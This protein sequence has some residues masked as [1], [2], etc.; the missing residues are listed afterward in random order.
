MRRKIRNCFTGSPNG[1]LL[2]AVVFA[3]I[4]LMHSVTAQERPLGLVL[5]ITGPIGPATSDY[6]Y[7]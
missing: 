6:I 3:A 2:L 1:T 4:A 5:D 7:A